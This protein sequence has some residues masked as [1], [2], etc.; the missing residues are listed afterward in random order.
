[1]ID[2]FY[3]LYSIIENS[4][5]NK[6]KIAWFNNLGDSNPINIQKVNS[7]YTTF[8]EF[9]AR[10][11]DKYL[12]FHDQEPI[13]FSNQQTEWKEFKV[14]FNKLHSNHILGNSEINSE[15]K[16]KLLNFLG[17]KDFYWFSNGFLSL[18]WYRFYRYASH[19]EKNFS[20]KF[21]FSSYNRL[22]YQRLHRPIISGAL[23]HYA[24]NKIILSCEKQDLH[25]NKD[26]RKTLDY[27]NLDKRYKSYIDEIFKI[28]NDIRLNTAN[29][30]GNNKSYEIEV[31]DFIDSFCHIITERLFF[32]NRIHLTEKC[33][34]PIICCRPFI[35][36]S[37]P[38]SLDYLKNYGFKTFSNFWDESYDN[39]YNHYKRLDKIIDV[40]SYLSTLTITDL[41]NML[42]SMKDILLYNRHHFYN[43]FANLITTEL[44]NNL[45]N[46]INDTSSKKGYYYQI[47]DQLN[48][49]QMDKVIRSTEIATLEDYPEFDQIEFLTLSK[50]KQNIVF[51]K[52]LKYFAAFYKTINH[53]S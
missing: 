20:L 4:L 30:N 38:K 12:V 39:E 7:S 15:E 40:I 21:H 19:L 43:N 1:M 34:R 50:E 22:V 25:T 44:Y 23:L 17:Y 36:V 46:C 27:Q 5:S 24:N 9:V 3:N 52:N 51:E 11:K 32:E 42:D 41:H 48:A 13:D 18:E 26:I 28:T 37:T 53:N 33:F 2:P 8:E 49:T 16:N 29:Y 35:L 10:Y 14:R 47:F 6:I 31:T 45:N